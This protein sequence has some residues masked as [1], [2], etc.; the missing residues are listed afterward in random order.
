MKGNLYNELKP[1]FSTMVLV[2]YF[3]PSGFR[4]EM[5]PLS[6]SWSNWWVSYW[7]RNMGD[8][9]HPNS[10]LN[11]E[12]GDQLIN[13]QIGWFFRNFSAQ[14]RWFQCSD[15][16]PPSNHQANGGQHEAADAQG[17]R[18][19]ALDEQRAQRRG[20]AQHDDQRHGSRLESQNGGQQHAWGETASTSIDWFSWENLKGNFLGSRYFYR[21][22]TW[23]VQWIGWL[24]KI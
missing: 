10:H 15:S 16:H 4:A 3:Y 6:K 24:G 17:L 21:C 8:Q 19:E 11:R 12:N 9:Y 14:T 7:S 13:H 5:I 1:S 2:P 20:V 18:V 22:W 23:K